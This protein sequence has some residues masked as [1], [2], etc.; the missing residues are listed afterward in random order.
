L[1]DEI[2]RKKARKAYDLIKVKS[3]SVL[4]PRINYKRLKEGYAEFERLR[5]LIK[6]HEGAV[7]YGS[8]PFEHYKDEFERA[9]LDDVLSVLI[10]PHPKG[11]WRWDVILEF[12]AVGSAEGRPCSTREEAERQVLETLGIL[13]CKQEAAPGYT[14]VGNTDD[15]LQIV[16]DHPNGNRAR[17]NA[18]HLERT[19]AQTMWDGVWRQFPNLSPEELQA[20]AAC[21]VLT[22]DD[23]DVRKLTLTLLAHCNWTH[24]TDEIIDQWCEENGVDLREVKCKLDAVRQ[25]DDAGIDTAALVEEVEKNGIDITYHGIELRADRGAVE[26]AKAKVAAMSPQERK[27]ERKKLIKVLEGIQAKVNDGEQVTDMGVLFH[28]MCDLHALDAINVH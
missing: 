16:F 13:G 24:V 9:T 6:P 27:T 1:V 26:R 10:D 4:L 2:A 18:P 20:A 19:E 14:P 25:L 23:E 12:T 5:P 21:M 22:G 28:A 15:Y 8:L 3:P 7:Q 11:G 17:F